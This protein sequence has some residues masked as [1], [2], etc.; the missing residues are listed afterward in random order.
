MTDQQEL[1]SDM[2]P[3]IK[4]TWPDANNIMSFQ[5]IIKPDEN[6]WKG[7]AF[8]FL[9]NVTDEYPIQAPKVLCKK[10]RRGI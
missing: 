10:V 7:G 5:V 2:P 9:V 4:V 8:P 6:I 1:N 3:Q